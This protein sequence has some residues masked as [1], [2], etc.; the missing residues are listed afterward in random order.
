MDCAA[1][2]AGGEKS[3]L[4][5]LEIPDLPAMLIPM[6]T[7]AND[8]N[9]LSRR[10]IPQTGGRRAHKA[11]QRITAILFALRTRDLPIIEFVFE[12]ENSS[13]Q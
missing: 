3:S 11:E 9:G 5:I 4:R 12:G 1:V 2:A 7:C 8:N 10:R 6:I 13:K